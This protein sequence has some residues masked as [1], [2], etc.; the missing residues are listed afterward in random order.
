[1]RFCG[2]IRF[3]KGLLLLFFYIAGFVF[4]SDCVGGMSGELFFDRWSTFEKVIIC[5]V[6]EKNLGKRNEWR[7][8]K[9]NL[10]CGKWGEKRSGVGWMAI[11]Y[12]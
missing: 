12:V 2:I 8:R 6:S 4:K 1:M 5:L 11:V 10:G 3:D 7:E 9:E